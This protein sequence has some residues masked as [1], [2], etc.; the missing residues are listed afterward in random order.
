MPPFSHAT[1]PSARGFFVVTP[2]DCDGDGVHHPRIPERCPLRRRG[3]APCRI[4]EHHRRHRKTGPGFPLQ[5]IRCTTHQKHFTLYPPGYGPYLRQPVEDL[6]PDGTAPVGPRDA[7]L[8]AFE[9]TLFDA[10]L[11]A[12]RGRP[13]AR[14]TS[15]EDPPPER[16][17]S[18]QGRHLELLLRMLGLLSGMQ[19]GLR[20]AIAAVLSLDLMLLLELARRVAGETGYRSKGKAIVEVLRSLAPRRDRAHRLLHCSHLI[21]HLALPL[22]WNTTRRSLERLAFPTP[23]PDVPP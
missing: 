21:G 9:G 8:H 11:D 16:W 15:S 6:A 22:L 7:P 2:Y 4:T 10:A 14:D 19:D 12:A 5:V 23:E 20:E 18:T 3:D 13:W 1:R 17:W